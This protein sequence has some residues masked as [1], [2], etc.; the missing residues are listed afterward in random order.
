MDINMK[1]EEP[2]ISLK[3]YIAQYRGHQRFTRL[4]SII[5]H[6]RSDNEKLV[7]EAIQLA[8]KLAAESK[9]L[10]LWKKLND[11]TARYF[12]NQNKNVP[13]SCQSKSM[14]ETALQAE[15]DTLIKKKGMEI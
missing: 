11:L 3:D 15:Y 1:N 8:Y 6:G 10:G 12:K 13:A 2:A 7:I 5:E 4:F 14:N 9:V